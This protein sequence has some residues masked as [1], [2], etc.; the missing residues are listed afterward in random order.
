MS[1]TLHMEDDFGHGTTEY[2]LDGNILSNSE[3]RYDYDEDGFLNGESYFRDCILKSR[4][5]YEVTDVDIN[6]LEPEDYTAG[7]RRT[8]RRTKE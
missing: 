8:Q 4:S 6:P 3:W 1:I 2:D 7:T 5:I